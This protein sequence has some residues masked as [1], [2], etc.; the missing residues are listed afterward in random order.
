MDKRLKICF[1]GEMVWY[2]NVLFDPSQGEGLLQVDGRA[3][4]C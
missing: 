1:G 4:K 2:Q 3:A